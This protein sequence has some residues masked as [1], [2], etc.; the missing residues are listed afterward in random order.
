MEQK[1]NRNGA[2]MIFQDNKRATPLR[3]SINGVSC[4]KFTTAACGCGI[5]ADIGHWMIGRG[6]QNAGLRR[7]L[8]S[9]RA[10][11]RAL[12]QKVILFEAAASS[13]C[14]RPQYAGE[15]RGLK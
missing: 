10:G 14:L 8:A 7:P 1:N 5:V 9:S 15:S 2:E 12:H 6:K 13:K 11:D 4:Y 3:I